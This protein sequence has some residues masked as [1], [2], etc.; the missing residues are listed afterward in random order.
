MG[1]NLVADTPLS[2]WFEK[3]S[4]VFAVVKLL[5]FLIIPLYSLSE[6]SPSSRAVDMRELIELSVSSAKVCI[7]SCF[8]ALRRKNLTVTMQEVDTNENKVAVAIK[9]PPTTTPT[10]ESEAA[11]PE[12]VRMVATPPVNAHTV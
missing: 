3:R 7:F 9:G 4:L 6:I 5:Y 10:A 1:S 2:T 12:P 8:F 11:S